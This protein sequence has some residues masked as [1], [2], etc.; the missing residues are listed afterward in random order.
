L[1]RIKKEL[2]WSILVKS[3]STRDLFLWVLDDGAYP[4]EKGP[5]FWE[6]LQWYENNGETFIFVGEKT[7]HT[8]V[9]NGKR[10][11]RRKK[12]M[13]GEQKIEQQDRTW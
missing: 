9:T 13:K 3:R 2:M 10:S 6:W 5:I 8:K 1:E 11:Q 7:R 4:L 12:N